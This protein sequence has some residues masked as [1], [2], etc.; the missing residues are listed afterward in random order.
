M[1]TTISI[2]DEY[3]KKIKPRLDTLGY[4]TVNEFLLDLIRHQFD[5]AKPIVTTLKVESEKT[6]NHLGE[7]WNDS[8]IRSPEDVKERFQFNP[9]LSKNTQA[10]GGMR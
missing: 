9:N 2:P 10:K 1:R 5:A 6:G 8:L 4:S 7:A 3:Y